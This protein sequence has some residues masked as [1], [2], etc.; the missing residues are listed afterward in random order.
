VIVSASLRPTPPS[1]AWTASL[2]IG[3]APELHDCLL[4]AGHIAEALGVSGD[5]QAIKM[6]EG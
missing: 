3:G 2:D 6:D 1:G 4:E 5:D